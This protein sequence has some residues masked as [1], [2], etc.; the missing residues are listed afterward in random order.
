MKT[1]SHAVPEALIDLAYTPDRFARPAAAGR[2]ENGSG[3]RTSRE[4][5]RYSW[6]EDHLSRLEG[7]EARGEYYARL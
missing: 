4:D 1:A 7:K 3:P 5:Y 6:I 2:C